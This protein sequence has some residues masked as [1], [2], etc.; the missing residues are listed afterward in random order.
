MRITPAAEHLGAPHEHACIMLC[1]GDLLTDGRPEAGPACA[2]VELRLGTEEVL[3]AADAL[4]RSTVLQVVVC[5]CESSF[6]AFL[7]GYPELLRCKNLLPFCIGLLDLVAH[8]WTV[9]SQESGLTQLLDSRS[10]WLYRTP[11]RVST[12][13]A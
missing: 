1:A 2:G 7:A 4:V 3:P 8:G 9:L 11:G 6:G 12:A 10:I 5:A 13:N